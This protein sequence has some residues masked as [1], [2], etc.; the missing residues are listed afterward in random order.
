MTTSSLLRAAAFGLALFLPNGPA[1]AGAADYVFEAVTPDV[2]N[3]AGSELRVRLVHRPTG[4]PVDGALIVKTRLDMAPDNMEAMMAKHAAAAPAGEPGVYRFTADL[5]ME[6]S[7]ALKLM[8]KI[9]GEPETVI[10][11]VVFKTKK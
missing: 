9:Q 3:G 11:T 6:G 8:A 2:S 5:T 7:W 1:L 10:A 4:K